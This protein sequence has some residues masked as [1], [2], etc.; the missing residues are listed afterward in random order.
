M[1]TRHRQILEAIRT[2][3][4]AVPEV[5]VQRSACAAMGHGQMV[6][7]LAEHAGLGAIAPEVQGWPCTPPP[8]G[9]SCRE[10]GQALLSGEAVTSHAASWGLA[11]VN[12]SLSTPPAAL[13]QKGQEVMHRLGAGMRVAV[14]GHFPFVERMAG[15]FASFQVLERKPRPGDVDNRDGQAAAAILPEVDVAVITGTSLLNGTLGELLEL[16][17]P[18]CKVILLGPSTP[19]APSLFDCGIDVLAG[20]AVCTP[21]ETLDAVT[22]GSCFRSLPGVV[23]LAWEG[24]G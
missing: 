4:H 11:A 5:F 8:A 2:D 12:A 20:A 10:L 16:V 23:H 18:G 13:E 22:R 9:E 17:P 6:G 19:F 21:R 1:N 3:L 15:E 7:I 24:R 14:V